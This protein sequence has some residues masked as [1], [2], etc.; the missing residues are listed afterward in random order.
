MSQE[1]GPKWPMKTVLYRLIHHH[2]LEFNPKYPDMFGI[3]IGIQIAPVVV[4]F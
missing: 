3:Q 1:R 2:I 4:L